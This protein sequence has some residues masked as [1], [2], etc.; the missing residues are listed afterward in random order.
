MLPFVYCGT[1]WLGSFCQ[2]LPTQP[3]LKI[4]LHSCTG[5]YTNKSYYKKLQ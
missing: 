5:K 2:E 4:D 1:V 3:N